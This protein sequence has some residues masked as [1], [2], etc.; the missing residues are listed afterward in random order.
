MKRLLFRMLDPAEFLSDHGIRSLSR[1]YLDKPYVY[2]ADGTA[3]VVNY[4]PAESQSEH[5]RRQL[6]LARRRSGFRSTS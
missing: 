2:Q 3:F 4:E 6:Q 1:V 5:V